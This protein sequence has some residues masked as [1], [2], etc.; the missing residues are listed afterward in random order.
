MYKCTIFVNSINNDGMEGKKKLIF[1]VNPISGTQNKEQI[2]NLL[3]ERIDREL[4]EY[5]IVRTEYA[6]H[7]AEIASQAA[8]E[9]IWL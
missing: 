4:Y 8:T 6:G 7:A 2:L 1:I 3:E 9:L 5:K